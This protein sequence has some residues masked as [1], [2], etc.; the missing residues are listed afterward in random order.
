[1]YEKKNR[2]EVRSTLKTLREDSGAVRVQGKGESSPRSE[3]RR[4]VGR[5]WNEIKKG[6]RTE[7]YRSRVSRKERARPK[8]RDTDA[9]GRNNN[10]AAIKRE[11][12]HVGGMPLIIGLKFSS[13]RNRTRL[14][15]T[16]VIPD[17]GQSK[18]FGAGAN[19]DCRPLF[20]PRLGAQ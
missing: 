5:S 4:Q 18:D 6:C 7:A 16:G 1:V 9:H 8:G 20:H 2:G 13:V 12:L 19:I 11:F 17:G 15:G 10:S 14:L 3:T